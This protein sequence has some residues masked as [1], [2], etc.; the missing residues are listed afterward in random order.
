M[1]NLLHLTQHT[2]YASSYAIYAVNPF[3]EV[4]SLTLIQY[5]VFTVSLGKEHLVKYMF[6]WTLY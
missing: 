4:Q 5:H 1:D 3:M 2:V 6:F